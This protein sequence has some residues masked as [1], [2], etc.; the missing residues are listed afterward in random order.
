MLG[1]TDETGS[2]TP[3]P[4]PDVL[5]RNGSYVILRKLY[6]DV[7][8]FRRYIRAQA[9]DQAEEELLAASD[10]DSRVCPPLSSIVVET[11]ASSQASGRYA[12]SESF[13]ANTTLGRQI[14]R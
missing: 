11:T 9:S 13:W 2:V 12:G 8:A 1:Y 14:C 7:A 10:A 4:Q 5:G 3:F 6:T